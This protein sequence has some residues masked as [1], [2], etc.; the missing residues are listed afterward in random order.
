[1]DKWQLAVK[2]AAAELGLQIFLFEIPDGFLQMVTTK[3]TILHCN[4]GESGSNIC[5]L[6]NV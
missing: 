6:H 2:T 5:C 3:L 1:M 4:R